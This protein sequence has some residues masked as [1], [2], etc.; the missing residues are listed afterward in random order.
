MI[1]KIN[2]DESTLGWTAYNYSEFYGRKLSE[3]IKLRL[4]T[5]EP[6]FRVKTMTRLSNELE[7]LPPTF[8]SMSRWGDQL[9]SRVRD[10]GWCG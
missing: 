5:E 2:L 8:N 7:N 6:R 10:Q 1:E 3:G 4:G 9:I